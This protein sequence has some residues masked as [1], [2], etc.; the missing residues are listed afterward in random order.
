MVCPLCFVAAFFFFGGFGE[1][2]VEEEEEELGWRGRFCPRS[3]PS[4]SH[5][6]LSRAGGA[7]G[8]PSSLPAG[9]KSLSTCSSGTHGCGDLPNVAHRP[10]SSCPCIL[11]AAHDVEARTWADQDEAEEAADDNH[12]LAPA[13]CPL[14]EHTDTGHMKG[15]REAVGD[16]KTILTAKGKTF[17]FDFSN[18]FFT[19]QKSTDMPKPA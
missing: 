17:I 9:V 6:K 14:Q 1:L 3:R 15:I 16:L 18:S 2:G 10:L 13:V 12:V 8:G 5:S 7:G 11:Q 4:S 19:F